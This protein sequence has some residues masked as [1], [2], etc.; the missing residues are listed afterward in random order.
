[1][2]G[3]RFLAAGTCSILL[4][5]SAAGDVAAATRQCGSMDRLAEP[6]LEVIAAPGIQGDSSGRHQDHHREGDEDGG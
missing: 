3:R 4:W 2:N 6:R 1:M 5:L